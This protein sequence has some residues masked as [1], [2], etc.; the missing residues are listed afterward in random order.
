[1]ALLNISQEI[2][3]EGDREKM[4]MERTWKKD[5]KRR[6]AFLLSFELLQTWMKFTKG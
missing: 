1:M 3:S 2:E 5:N 6:P 4:E